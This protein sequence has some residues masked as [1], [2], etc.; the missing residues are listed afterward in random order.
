MIVDALVT[1]PRSPVGSL[2]CPHPRA[3][4]RG[5]TNGLYTEGNRTDEVWSS[6]FCR[7]E[8]W[9]S[10][11]VIEGRGVREVAGHFI[12][13]MSQEKQLPCQNSWDLT[14]DGHLA[15]ISWGLCTSS[16]QCSSF[17]ASSR[18]RQQGQRY[19]GKVVLHRSVVW[20]GSPCHRVL[21]M[22]NVSMGSRGD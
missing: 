20:C 3:S 10:S 12:G 18:R 13:V 9:D 8:K 11:P 2:H 7:A 4:S 19:Q 5:K 14:P 15:E 6:G 22:L 1:Y 16:Q 21:W 17:L